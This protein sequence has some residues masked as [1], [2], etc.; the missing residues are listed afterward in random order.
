MFPGSHRTFG[1]WTLLA[2]SSLC[3]PD[4][5]LQPPLLNGRRTWLR[6]YPFLYSVFPRKTKHFLPNMRVHESLQQIFI[7][8]D[9]AGRNWVQFWG[10]DDRKIRPSS[11]VRDTGM[12]TKVY[13]MHDGCPL[14]SKYRVQKHHGKWAVSS[15][16][17][18][19]RRWNLYL[20]DSRSSSAMGRRHEGFQIRDIL[21][22][23][24]NCICNV[25]SADSG[26]PFKPNDW[27]QIYKKSSFPI[28]SIHWTISAWLKHR[29]FLPLT[30][31]RPFGK[32]R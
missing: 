16:G 2:T 30:S 6:H 19:G 21:L 9:S 7:K 26:R 8:H 29:E 20:K 24:R 18:D 1:F 11:R 15:I 14:R 27:N 32:H 25:L 22:L 4:S 17:D 31:S 13:A 23:F 10:E 12:K 28:I 3:V 5:A